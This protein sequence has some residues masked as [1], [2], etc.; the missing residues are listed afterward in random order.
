VFNKG[1]PNG[2]III[3][4]SGDQISP[5]SDTGTKD[6]SKKTQKILKKNINSVK[7]NKII[8]NLKPS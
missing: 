5:I 4:P 3:N 2:L 1:T 7:I 8:P 6:E